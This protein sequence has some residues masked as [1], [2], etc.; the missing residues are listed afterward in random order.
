MAD[1]VVISDATP[2][3]AH[4]GFALTQSVEWSYT[5]ECWRRFV[6][7]PQV[8]WAEAAPAIGV[9]DNDG[10]DAPNEILATSCVFPQGA[11]ATVGSTIVAPE[12]QRKGLGSK[13]VKHDVA[14]IEA[15]P[16]D[17]RPKSLYLSATP[18]GQ[19]VYERIGFR[20]IS[21]T[22]SWGGE[23]QEENVAQAALKSG[24]SAVEVQRGSIS[25]NDW[26]QAVAL[27]DA[28]LE[29]DRNSIMEM[30]LLS[31]D[32]TG[33]SDQ[34]TMLTGS[35]WA[36]TRDQDGQIAA[37]A[38]ARPLLKGYTV[39]P[40]I[41]NDRQQAQALLCGLFREIAIIGGKD[42]PPKVQVDIDA[43]TDPELELRKYLSESWGLKETR[44]QALME[45][46]CQGVQAPG[47]NEARRISWEQGRKRP[48][49]Q[50]AML[51]LSAM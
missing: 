16:E 20:K 23:L 43:S 6:A 47:P 30:M 11:S 38:A 25:S 21:E 32:Q 15:L 13:L 51:D 41:A 22:L 37:F 19:P 3:D 7:F 27:A 45:Y 36:A 50:Y 44:T 17:S 4:Y 10:K 42:H 1:N 8:F 29:L 9:N 40:L 14:F 26:R 35:L 5:L 34:Q 39:G 49:F 24:A 28:A 48:P 46:L 33:P 12:H 2:Q 18:A 31:P